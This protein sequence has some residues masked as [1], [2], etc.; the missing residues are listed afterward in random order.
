MTDCISMPSSAIPSDQDVDHE[1]RLLE[2]LAT[3]ADPRSRQGLRHKL[4]SIL[5]IVRR[6]RSWR[7]ARRRTVDVAISGV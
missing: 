7:F 1:A 5:I 6:Q 4:A 2:R 3:L